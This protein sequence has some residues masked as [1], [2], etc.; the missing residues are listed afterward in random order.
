MESLSE[1]LHLSALYRYALDSSMSITC[2]VLC[3]LFATTFINL[4]ALL[5]DNSLLHLVGRRGVLIECPASVV[6]TSMNSLVKLI[7]GIL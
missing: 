7:L 2:I 6:R 4:V 1:S 5:S 3:E